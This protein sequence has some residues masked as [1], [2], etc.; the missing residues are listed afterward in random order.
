VTRT[1]AYKSAPSSAVHEPH[2]LLELAPGAMNRFR[3]SIRCDG[4][5]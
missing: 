2:N 4:L 5:L 3:L 1:A